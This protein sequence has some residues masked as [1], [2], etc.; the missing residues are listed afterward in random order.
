M[1]IQSVAGG[2]PTAAELSLDAIAEGQAVLVVDTSP[3]GLLKDELEAAGFQYLDDVRRLFTPI[4][5]RQTVA[6]IWSSSS[7]WFGE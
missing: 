4:L 1:S 7:I 6:N 3:Y 5:E 2:T